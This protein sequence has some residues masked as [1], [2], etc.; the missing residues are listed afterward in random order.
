MVIAI[1][2]DIVCERIEQS[3]KCREK[4]IRLCSSKVAVKYF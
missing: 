3:S 2:S 4:T 1:L